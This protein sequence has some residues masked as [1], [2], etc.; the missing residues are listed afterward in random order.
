MRK[1]LARVAGIV[2]S[3]WLSVEPGSQA[4]LKRGRRFPA[5]FGRRRP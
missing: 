1:G 4:L 3:L 5:R 2:G